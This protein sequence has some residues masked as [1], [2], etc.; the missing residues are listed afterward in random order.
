MNGRSTSSKTSRNQRP[1]AMRQKQGHIQMDQVSIIFGSGTTA[2]QAVKETSLEILPGEFVCI[3]GPSG[4]GK[5]TLLN[6]VAGYVQPTM[7][8]VL[9]DGVVITKPGPDRGMVFQG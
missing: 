2:N 7:G 9:V 6:S 8:Q 1:D 3:L 5:S 4:C